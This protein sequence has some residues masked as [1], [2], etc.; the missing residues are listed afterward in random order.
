MCAV[1]LKVT[2]N[3]KKPKLASNSIE[4]TSS[5]SIDNLSRLCKLI[6]FIDFQDVLYTF[7][8]TYLKLNFN[9]SQKKNTCFHVS[10]KIE[11]LN[12]IVTQL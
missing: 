10:K 12:K 8:S 3:Q 9:S 6:T 11:F 5:L 1:S 2:F 7:I 4:G